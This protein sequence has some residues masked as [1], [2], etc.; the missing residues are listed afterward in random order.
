MRAARIAV[1]E[2]ERVVAYHLS[3]QLKR[4]GYSIAFIASSGKQVLERMQDQQPDVIL[5]DISIDGDMDG[6]ET[7]SR[8]PSDPSIPIIYLTA[9]SE[10][11]TLSRARQTKPYGYL[12]KP[13]SE[14][15]LH[16]TI[17]MA[18]ERKDVELS[19]RDSRE[20]LSLALDAAD[21]TPWEFS[22]QDKRF[23]FSG[24]ERV[25][26]SCIPADNENELD[27]GSVLKAIQK[28]DRASLAN[29]L[30]NKDDTKTGINLDFRR[31]TQ[32]GRVQWLRAQGRRRNSEAKGERIVGVL[33]DVTAVKADEERR[34][35]AATIFE[36]TRDGL[37]ILDEAFR[38]VTANP[39]YQ[40]MT[41][42]RE[43]E[44]V[45]MRPQVLDIMAVDQQTQTQIADAL[46][47][48]GQWRGDLHTRGKD[49]S[50]IYL[51]ANIIALHGEA[52][53]PVHY[54]VA[55]SDLTAIRKAEKDLQYLAHFDRLTGLP[56]RAL[57]TDRL[58][59][60]ISRGRRERNKLAL[61][62]ID[63]DDFKRINDTLGHRAGDEVLKVAANRMRNQVRN[64]DTVARF[65]GDEFMVVLERID[66]VE[67]AASV[68]R[69][70]IAALSQPMLIEGRSISVGAS[71][72]IGIYPSDGED[73]DALIQAADTAMY[74]A[75]N[76]GRN[77]FA[78]YSAQ[79]TEQVRSIMMREQELREALRRNELRLFFQPQIR[80]NDMAVEGMEALIRWQHPQRG[81]LT[82]D[83]VIPFAERSELI[84][85]IGEWV[86]ME[87]C[88]QIV[89]W[90]ALGL[91]RFR[92]A[93]NASPAQMRDG[94][95]LR[96][97]DAAI[98]TYG[99][100]PGILEI[101]IT[102]NVSQS[103]PDSIATLEALQ[104]MGVSVSID[105]F[106]IGYSCLSSLKSLPI[107]RLKI[108]R[109]FISGL[110]NDRNDVML[111][112]TIIAIAHRLNLN[113]VAE[114]I[115]TA[116]QSAF[117]RAHHCEAVQGF[118]YAKPM[119]AEAVP[120]FL[121]EWQGGVASS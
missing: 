108:D 96:S 29:S 43:E 72:G 32:D 120:D 33:R 121:A 26:F 79:M 56:N 46:R 119:S 66:E 89:A 2:D 54:V 107:Q 9:Y 93:V 103:D 21:M 34:R 60:A 75:K 68:A 62:F 99:V 48:T 77:G 64:M 95:L 42:F 19:L 73:Q 18:I 115:E 47:E 23:R 58:E 105:D 49:G 57:A 84:V 97:I 55:C 16:A 101:E 74:A 113:V 76:A 86:L 59:H 15:E 13:F 106:G 61:L 38:V 117:L 112:E 51:F 69:K 92:V 22:P 36:A 50:V 45:G 5:M 91:P 85:D 71:I 6:I 65:A 52:G 80:L 7:A 109:A 27:F 3:Q 8:L 118:Y 67:N 20:H 24:S 87:A 94:R 37:L 114:G 41:G 63:L 116:E 35:Q 10:E 90:Q 30:Y 17:Q 39:G 44:L 104:K 110:P 12:L 14:R 25:N 88:R 40:E 78:F 111:T 82:A 81:L 53:R 11:E 4:M 102:E 28:E 98:K 31:H 1:V 83:E 70:L 100:T